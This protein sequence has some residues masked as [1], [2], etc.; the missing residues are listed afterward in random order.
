MAN[1]RGANLDSQRKTMSTN[2]NDNERSAAQDSDSD[3]LLA[4]LRVIAE[5]AGK[6]I[7]A[8]YAE[9]D[10]IEV[11]HKEDQSPVTAADEAAEEFILDA[12]AKLTPEIPVIAEI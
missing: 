6:I 7:L 2:A 8:Y 9:G 5:R 3:D 10:A 4:V 1:R 12:L 11:A